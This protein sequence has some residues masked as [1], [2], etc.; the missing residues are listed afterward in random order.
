MYGLECDAVGWLGWECVAVR[1]ENV[2]KG[3]VPVGVLHALV[4]CQWEH[5]VLGVQA[6][7]ISQLPIQ[8]VWSATCSVASVHEQCSSAAI[9]G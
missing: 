7:V 2:L 6:P 1:P 3:L 9:C 5:P 8:T 4:C